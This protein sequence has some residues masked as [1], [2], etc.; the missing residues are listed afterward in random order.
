MERE[1]AVKQA[2]NVGKA[3]AML[4]EIAEGL[5]DMAGLGHWDWA[6]ENSS[7]AHRITKEIKRSGKITQE[8]QAE[9]AAILS[10]IK[11]LQEWHKGAEEDTH[12]QDLD[13]LNAI[14][15]GRD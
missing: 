5:A 12:Q 8:Q 15:E 10:G 7:I 11:E 3:N 9:L 2:T 14:A 1:T 4:D 6:C 13:E